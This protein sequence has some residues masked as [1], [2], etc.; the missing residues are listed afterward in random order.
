MP[1]NPVIIPPDNKCREYGVEPGLRSKL[2]KVKDY[3][4]TADGKITGLDWNLW[5]D[6]QMSK[7]EF[8]AAMKYSLDL[9]YAGNRCPFLFGGHSDIYSDTYP[10]TI[11]NATPQER[12]DALSEFINYA[13]RKPDVRI[14]PMKQVL[15]WLR[16]PVALQ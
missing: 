16:N 4:D 15:D 14:A 2:A 13:L 5:V 7:A 8:L 9:R 12:R 10:D 1:C 3:L 11:A 6:F